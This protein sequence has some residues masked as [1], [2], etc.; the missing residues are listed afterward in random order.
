MPNRRIG[1]P[2]R[3]VLGARL[4]EP[5][6]SLSADPHLVLLQRLE[7]AARPWTVQAIEDATV[8]VFGQFE[9]RRSLDYHA[10]SRHAP[11]LRNRCH[12]SDHAFHLFGFLR[13]AG[14]AE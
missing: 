11:W 10:T 6:F 4:L 5:F 1:R 9:P 13:S 2:F 14:A 12:V 8:E 3:T 7:P